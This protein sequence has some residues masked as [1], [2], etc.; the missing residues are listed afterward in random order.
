MS[1]FTQRRVTRRDLLLTAAR[2]GVATAV[3]VVLTACDGGAV[4]VG[5]RRQIAALGDPEGG[6]LAIDTAGNTLLV[7]DGVNLA[8]RT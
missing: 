1:D 6:L 4:A 8:W 2:A 7:S 3:P 5:A